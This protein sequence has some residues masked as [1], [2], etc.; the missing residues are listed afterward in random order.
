MDLILAK[1]EQLVK[2]VMIV[3]VSLGCHGHELVGDETPNGSEQGQQ[4]S[5]DLGLQRRR[6]G[7]TQETETSGAMGSSSVG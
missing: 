5:T 6:L 3:S 4:E 1:K 2:D 7:H